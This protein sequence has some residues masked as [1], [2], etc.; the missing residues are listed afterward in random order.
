MAERQGEG[1]FGPAQTEFVLL[2]TSFIPEI[3]RPS[4]R[5]TE[6]TVELLCFDFTQ[7][8]SEKKSG[9]RAALGRNEDHA[10][11]SPDLA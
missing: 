2:S 6:H 3:A 11:N 10:R 5:V 8:L 7:K 1:S 9:S 4:L